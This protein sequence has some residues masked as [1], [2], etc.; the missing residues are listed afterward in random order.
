[1][2]IITALIAQEFLKKQKGNVFYDLRSSW[3]VKEVIAENGGTPMMSRVGHAFI[4]AQMRA[5]NA[6]FAG[7]LSGHYYFRENYFAESS[8]LAALSIA[9]LVSA[10][11]SRS[12]RWSSPSSAILRAARSIAKSTTRRRCWHS[13]ARN[14][15]AAR[16]TELD[17]LPLNS[18][19][20]GFKC[21]LL[22]YR[23]ARPAEPRGQDQGDDGTEA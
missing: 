20:G 14:I 16:F 13:C 19:I 11:A 1:M 9:N 3:A 5:A 23:A 12:P 18:A 21:P 10:A 15:P 7:E 6:I 22:E 4:K 17:G 2:D 8:S